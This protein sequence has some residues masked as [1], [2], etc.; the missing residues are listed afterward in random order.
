LHLA[1]FFDA[2]PVAG[3][4]S[5]FEQARAHLDRVLPDDDRFYSRFAAPADQFQ[6]PGH[7]F[8]RWTSRRDEEPLDLKKLGIFP[9]VH[10]VRAMALKYG[11]RAQGTAA[12]LAL[13]GQA[14][15]I[16][17]PLAS[18]LLQALHWL[19]GLRLT[20]QLRQREQGL[21]VS[22]EVRPSELATLEREPLRDALAI[23]RR[24][25][26]FLRHHFRLDAL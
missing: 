20:H 1:I 13:L 11:V 23:V 17:E 18:D 15:R 26:A 16:E 21:P 12:R 9:I 6:E 25:R 8:K 14:Q 5:L 2:T 3:D 19:M 22:N 24:W 10:G 7:W 4:A